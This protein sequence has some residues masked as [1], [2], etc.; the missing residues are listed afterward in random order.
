MQILF[1]VM[2]MRKTNTKNI[3]I[4]FG[5]AVVAAVISAA[6]LVT[7]EK[8]EALPQEPKKT[9][10]V[11]QEE[12]PTPQEEAEQASAAVSKAKYVI[13]Q[14]GDYL[15]VY[16]GDYQTVYAYTDITFGEL[17]DDLKE[18]VAAGYVFEDEK[19]LYDFLENY[20]S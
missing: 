10:V 14:E 7:D 8:E 5:I 2:N 6:I 18:K 1:V 15:T 20:T 12:E 13:M 11:R 9:V 16:Y 4:L 3:C 19:S 17:S